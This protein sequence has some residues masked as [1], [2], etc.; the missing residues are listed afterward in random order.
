M[1]TTT[2]QKNPV[3][4][5]A[6]RRECFLEDT[7]RGQLGHNL[8]NLAALVTAVWLALTAEAILIPILVYLAAGNVLVAIY[9]SLRTRDYNEAGEALSKED[10]KQY[11]QE[12]GIRPSIYS[13]V[14]IHK[15][16][17]NSLLTQGHRAT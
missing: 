16:Y 6:L 15:N 5:S 7:G 10:F 2:V 9:D 14:E 12:K 8:L 1:A 13:I 4:F 3:D 17:K 11:I